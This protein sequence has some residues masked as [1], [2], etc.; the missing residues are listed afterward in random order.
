M[1][2]RTKTNLTLAA[3]LTVIKSRLLPFRPQTALLQRLSSLD[4]YPPSRSLSHLITMRQYATVYFIN[5]EPSTTKIQNSTAHQRMLT[6]CSNNA[7]TRTQPCR[8][9]PEPH[10][11]GHMTQFQTPQAPLF[12]IHQRRLTLHFGLRRIYVDV[13]G[14]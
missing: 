11:S 6:G 5:G 2:W 8:F 10:P 9:L 13:S 14:W 1:I 7:V 3:Y 4:Q 12:Q